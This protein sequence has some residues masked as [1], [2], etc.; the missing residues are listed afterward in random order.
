MSNS[1]FIKEGKAN[2]KAE[3]FIFCLIFNLGIL[4]KLIWNFN[5]ELN[6]LFSYLSVG[7][8]GFGEILICSI[9]MLGEEPGKTFLAQERH[10]KQ[11]RFPR[12]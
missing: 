7:G 8:E 1:E 6:G 5:G 11:S 4:L 9:T 3:V 12:F 2:G 10:E